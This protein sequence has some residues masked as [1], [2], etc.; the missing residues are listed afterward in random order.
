EHAPALVSLLRSSVGELE[1][2][3][4]EAALAGLSRR[5][6]GACLEAALEAWGGATA[7]TRVSLLR[8]LAVIGGPKA[9]NVVVEA[10][11]DRSAEVRDE[12]LGIL[13]S[14]LDP[15]VAPHLLEIARQTTD[16]S[17][18]AAALRGLVRLASADDKRPADIQALSAAWD[19]AKNADEQRLVLGA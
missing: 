18:R 7:R 19:L 12:A 10:R 2:D 14:W 9:L 3:A 8:C 16:Q 5:A 13:A 6:G 15:L 17:D 11:K 1:R 4:A